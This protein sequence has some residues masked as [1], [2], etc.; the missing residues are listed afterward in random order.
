ML[1]IWRMTTDYIWQVVTVGRQLHLSLWCHWKDRFG[2]KKK[3]AYWIWD[4]RGND[5]AN[6]SERCQALHWPIQQ[7]GKNT[8]GTIYTH[9]S[10]NQVLVFFQ[11]HYF[12]WPVLSVFTCK[13]VAPIGYSF[14]LTIKQCKIK[15]QSKVSFLTLFLVTRDRTV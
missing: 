14:L 15:K 6:D 13:L 1:F 11:L 3:N 12:L 7:G 4:L 9:R 5:V 8:G 10:L 2:V